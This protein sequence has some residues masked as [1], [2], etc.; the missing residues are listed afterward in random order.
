MVLKRENAAARL[1]DL[2]DS[3]PLR[4]FREG[5][6]RQKPVQH[7]HV[8][9][10]EC[11]EVTRKAGD[12]TSSG[13]FLG[14]VHQKVDVAEG[15]EARVGVEPGK[16]PALKTQWFQASLVE[17]HEYLLQSLSVAGSFQGMQAKCL[18]KRNRTGLFGPR[19]LADGPPTE[20]ATASVKQARCE[21]VETVANLDS[22]RVGCLAPSRADRPGQ[23]QPQVCRGWTHRAS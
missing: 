20:T 10:Y 12:N 4:E 3:W 6:V 2:L 21:G 16:G 11:R 19:R 15:S 9:I 14:G 18:V 13:A 5:A 1:A 17:L 23:E 8:E 7:S 22:Q